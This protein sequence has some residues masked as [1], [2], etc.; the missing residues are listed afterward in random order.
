MTAT[1]LSAFSQRPDDN[2]HHPFHV[3]EEKPQ[4]PKKL[5]RTLAYPVSA[6]QKSK[7]K[8]T[9]KKFF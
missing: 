5:E 2:S 1:R 3:D 9:V 4:E 7:L 8:R 6:L